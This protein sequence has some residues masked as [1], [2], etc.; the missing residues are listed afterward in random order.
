VGNPGGGGSRRGRAGDAASRD[1]DSDAFDVAGLAAFVDEY[2]TP[3]E[4]D[5]TFRTLRRVAL[6]YFALFLVV[7][8]AVPLLTWTLDWWSDG[9]LIGGMS[10]SFV[11][12]AF[13][14]YAFFFL[15]GLAVATLSTAVE[16]RMLGGA[17]SDD[18][19]I[20]VPT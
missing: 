20:A 9:R 19:D 11:M 13:G 5:A 2:D 4:V 8:V 16:E 10:P 7:V 6:G 15:V 12:A 3:D 1:D 18:D 14:L 17:A